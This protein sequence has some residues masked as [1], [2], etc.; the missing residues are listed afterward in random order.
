MNTLNFHILFGHICLLFLFGCGSFKSIGLKKTNDLSSVYI[1]SDVSKYFHADIPNWANFSALAKCRRT[2]NMKFLN[3]SNLK[4][5]FNFDYR[6]AVLLQQRVNVNIREAQRKIRKSFI[7]PQIEEKLFFQSRDEVL[8]NIKVF[9]APEFKRIHLVWVDP[10]LEDKNA[11]QKLKRLLK[12]ESFFNGHP[13]FISACKNQDE[14]ESY[15]KNQDWDDID[16]RFLAS[17]MFSSYDKN[18]SF[19][20]GFKLYIDDF[21]KGKTVFLYLLNEEVPKVV[22]GKFTIIR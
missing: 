6:Q 7:S 17:E 14:L 9:K 2:E 4:N 1:S 5:S 20:P 16:I 13:V 22:R 11:E 15:T 3:F 19:D 12:S 18:L 10:I 8:S 21:L